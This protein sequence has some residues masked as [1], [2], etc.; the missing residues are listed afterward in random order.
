MQRDLKALLKHL[1]ILLKI[2]ATAH[3]A[4]HNQYNT[5]TF[6]NIPNVIVHFVMMCN[7]DNTTMASS[8]FTCKCFAPSPTHR[9]QYIYMYINLKPF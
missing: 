6:A 8:K 4:D 1:E 7:I 9:C 5:T 3:A 2:F